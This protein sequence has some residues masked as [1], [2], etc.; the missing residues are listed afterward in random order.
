MIDF[1]IR[2]ATTGLLNFL[3][4]VLVLCIFA[5]FYRGPLWSRVLPML[6]AAPALVLLS[7]LRIVVLGVAADRFGADAAETVL[8]LTGEWV[9]LVVGASLLLGLVLCAERLLGTREAF[10]S[11]V[12]VH[13][14]EMLSQAAKVFAT[15]PTPQLISA[16]LL[17][18]AIS[19]VFLANPGSSKVE[20][21]RTPFR[22]FPPEIAGWSGSAKEI[23]PGIANVLQA[24]DYV[25]IDYYHAEEPA[26]VNFWS[27]Y[28]DT[29]G[30]NRA[31]IHSPEAC[32]PGDGWNILSLRPVELQMGLHGEE[33]MII[34]RAIISKASE[35]SLIYYWFEGR[36]R[37]L[38][39]ERESKMLSKYD[40]VIKGRTD[41]A[42]V[43]F[44]TPIIDG[45]DEAVADARILRLMEPILD[46][47]PQFIPE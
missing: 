43:R 16:T 13:F 35:K 39:N 46:R 40:G 5:T 18:A 9:E 44:T 8:R 15:R 34:N 32:L 33:T 45:E 20:L 37:T 3:P 12:D 30:V 2:E 41:G 17:S 28:Y 24:D 36:G 6:L 38:A 27:A 14:G 29:T 23:Q 19:A 10:S 1:Q 42:L 7:A 4:L 26:P 31:Q 11:R 25:L 21:E 47:L 22:M